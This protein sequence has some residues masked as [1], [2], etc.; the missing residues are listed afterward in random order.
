MDAALVIFEG[1]AQNLAVMS[2]PGR[3][4]TRSL[5]VRTSSICPAP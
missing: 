4:F 1:M 3:N 5:E 2:A